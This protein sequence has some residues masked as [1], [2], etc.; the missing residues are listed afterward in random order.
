MTDLELE[1]LAFLGTDFAAS[2]A[3]EVGEEAVRHIFNAGAAAQR[4]I[5]ETQNT[6]I[7]EQ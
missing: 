1:L 2:I 6:E 3:A 7:H 5:T 4:C